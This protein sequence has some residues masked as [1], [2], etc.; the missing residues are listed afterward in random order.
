M[1]ARYMNELIENL[2]IMAN[3]RDG[4]IEMKQLDTKQ[5]SAEIKRFFFFFFGENQGGSLFGGQALL[6]RFF[7]SLV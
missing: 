2:L 1:Q 4:K 6:S 7:R 3:L 5:F